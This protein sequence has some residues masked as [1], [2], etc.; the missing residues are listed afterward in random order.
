MLNTMYLRPVLRQEAPSAE[1]APGVTDT[2]GEGAGESSFFDQIRQADDHPANLQ[3]KATADPAAAEKPKKAA[4]A[5]P[6]AQPLKKADKLA[7]VE[8]EPEEP[9]ADETTGEEKEELPPEGKKEGEE[10]EKQLSRW[11]QLRKEEK[12]AKELDKTVEKMTKEMEELRKNPVSK[13]VQAELEKL[14]QFQAIHDVKNTKDYKE[15]VTAKLAKAEGSITEICGEFKLDPDKMFEAMRETTDWKRQ[16]AIDK[17]IDDA[18]NVPS[19]IKASLYKQA[20]QLHDAWL[21]GHQIETNAAK[22]KA[23]QDAMSQQDSTKQTYEQQQAWQK[24]VAASKSVMEKKIAP[25][26]KG[27]SEAERKEFMDSLDNA[28]ISDDPEER[29]MQAHGLEVAAVVTKALIAERKTV[30]E[31]KKTVAS[32]TNARPGAKQASSTE[33]D[34]PNVI[35]DDDDFFAK[36]RQADD[37][38]RR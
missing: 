2:G 35:A 10:G 8:E 36:V 13:E 4:E 7:V 33:H 17:I 24:A 27:M 28:Q 6:A 18:D 12:R 21:K 31:L 11:N 22:L 9:D 23:A 32:L 38:R 5:K 37:F 20:D 15:N 16:V 29:A 19:A 14:R 25:I 30:A 1:A 3:K 26:I 34:D